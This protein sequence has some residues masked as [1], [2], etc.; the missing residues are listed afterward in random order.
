MGEIEPKFELFDIARVPAGDWDMTGTEIVRLGQI[1][2][3]ASK[4]KNSG[5]EAK[6]CLKTKEI[7][8]LNGANYARF[9]HELIAI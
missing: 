8:V 1:R 4:Y 5:N 2:R 3:I 7:T 9:A 6:K